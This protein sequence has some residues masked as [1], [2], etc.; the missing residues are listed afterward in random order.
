MA[1][2][3]RFSCPP[4]FE[5]AYEPRQIPNAK[6]DMSGTVIL[7]PKRAEWLQLLGEMVQMT[8]EAVRRRASH[9]RDATK[10]LSLEYMAD[11]IDVDEPLFGYLAVTADKAWMQG[12]ITCTTFT[13]WHCG[14][15]WD[16]LHPCVDLYHHEG[17][18]H[19]SDETDDKA[20]KPK[21]DADGSIAEELMT[22]MCAQSP[23][24]PMHAL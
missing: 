9:A 17:G 23:L 7:R 19:S 12:F 4:V 16:S 10:P 11:R 1:L 18:S 22:E 8:N 15:R 2:A 13:T 14:F 5:A 3:R 20:P 24:T 6:G 21:V